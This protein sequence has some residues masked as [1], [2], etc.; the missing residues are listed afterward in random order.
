MFLALLAAASFAKPVKRTDTDASFIKILDDRTMRDAIKKE[1]RAFVLFHADH[2]RL[3]DVAYSYYVSVA[4]EYRDKA[5][6]FVVPAAV[7]SDVARTY[8]V[9]G[10][11]SL[12]HFRR[13]TKLGTQHGL[14]S[15][16]SIERFV[17]NWTRPSFTEV[18]FRENAE[19]DEMWASL[20]SIVPDMQ[21]TVVIFGDNTTKFGR[22][23]V[24]LS[25]ELGTFFPF[26]RVT[27]RDAAKK[28]GVRFP[29][30]VM[31]RFDDSQRLEYTGEPDVD[32]MFIWAQ[33]AAISQFKNLDTSLLFSP[34][35]VAVKSAITFLNTSDDEQMDRVFRALGTLSGQQNWIRLYYADA[36]EQ[37]AARKLFGVEQLPAMV[38]LSANY[39]H[40]QFSVSSPEDRDSFGAFY[41]DYL[42]LKTVRTPVEMYGGLRPVTEFAF[43]KLA[44]EGPFFTLF[45]SAFCAKCK[46]MKMATIDAAKAIIANGG[47]T[48]WAFWDVTTATPS[49]QSNISLSIP[50]VWYFP[51]ANVTE[52]VPYMGPQNFLSVMEWA[53]G[54][55][56]DF[57]LDEFMAKELGGG[58]DTI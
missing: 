10:N 43:E 3:S 6:F 32:E 9:T 35:G 19:S 56:P 15:R 49:F 39:T 55:A 13:G 42:P 48:N 21:L 23:A 14:Y 41:E 24:E 11:P 28:M 47:K 37:K 52:G 25:E 20:S 1:K 5:N 54:Q 17:K 18:Q 50:S 4:R 44:E 40:C 51:T 31:V 45:T 53:H 2:Q 29:S 12:L 7:G 33:H 58:F 26:I 34:D 16:E 27:D 8:S 38:L 30:I 57:D 36:V 46:P 22:C